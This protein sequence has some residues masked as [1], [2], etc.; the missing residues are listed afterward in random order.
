MRGCLRGKALLPTLMVFFQVAPVGQISSQSQGCSWA[1]LLVRKRPLLPYRLNSF[2]KISVFHRSFS[3]SFSSLPSFSP[4]FLL[5]IC[6]FLF[7]FPSLFSAIHFPSLFLILS[8]SSLVRYLH[9][10]F[11]FFLSVLHSLF[12]AFFFPP[13]SFPS[14]LTFSPRLSCLSLWSSS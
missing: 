9:F 10:P 11:S 1:G 12:L 4:S 2:S 7:F 13:Q 14:P 5:F 3:L 6:S 8:F